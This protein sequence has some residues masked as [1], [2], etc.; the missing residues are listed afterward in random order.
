MKFAVIQYTQHALDQMDKRR[1]SKKQVESVL[2]RPDTTYESRGRH[3]A[4]RVTV[5]DNVLRVVY[6]ETPQGT[7]ITTAL[8]ITAIRIS[9][10]KA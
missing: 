5:H 8:V 7:V 3:V 1:I 9:G 4:E 10:G 2:Q 6:T